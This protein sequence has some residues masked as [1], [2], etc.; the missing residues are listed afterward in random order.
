MRRFLPLAL[1]AGAAVVAT[2]QSAPAQS[3]QAPA[4]RPPAAAAR[5]A[6]A[7]PALPAQKPYKSVA[8]AI[9]PAPQDPSFDA[10]RK[11]LA[12][13]AKRKDR[14]A[15]AQKVVAREF[16]WE[17]D[18]GGNF[19]PAK[20]SIDNL[21]T[22]LAL[23]ID[24]GSGWDALLAFANETTAGPLPGRPSIICAPA[25]PQ[26]DEEARNRLIET[27][28]TDGIDWNYPRASGLPMRAAPQANAPVVESLGLHFVRV[29]GFEEKE[30][31]LD[32]ARNAWL[33]VAGPS[34][35]AGFVAPNTLISSYTDRICYA[36]A[37]PAWRIVGYVGGGD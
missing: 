24:D 29:L 1:L 28:E 22:A 3:P 31:D 8:V 34:G 9:P 19:D 35:K 30:G 20:S 12:D 15:L 32:P 21:A 10:L 23:E 6:P 13:I 7:A 25:I 36:K 33:R 2:A 4:Q 5:P 26:F 14:A 16:F 11:E 17:R 37:G 27:T 18:F